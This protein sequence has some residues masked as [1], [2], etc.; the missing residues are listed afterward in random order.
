LVAVNMQTSLYWF[1]AG[2]VQVFSQICNAE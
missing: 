2:V 1:I